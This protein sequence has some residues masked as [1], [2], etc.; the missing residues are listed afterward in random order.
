[1]LH[2]R[3]ATPIPPSHVPA[4]V[5]DSSVA[6]RLTDVSKSFGDIRALAGLSLDIGTGSTVALLGPEWGR[7]VDRH[8]HHAGAAATR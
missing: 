3:A 7:Q 5:A 1:M 2:P 8:Q 6:V 4:S